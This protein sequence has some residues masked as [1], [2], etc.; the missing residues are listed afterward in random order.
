M[1]YCHRILISWFLYGLTN[2]FVQNMFMLLCFTLPLCS[3]WAGLNMLNKLKKNWAFL[4]PRLYI[5][6]NLDTW[7]YNTSLST[8]VSQLLFNH[9]FYILLYDN[10][11]LLFVLVNLNVWL[12]HPSYCVARGKSTLTDRNKI[13]LKGN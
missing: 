4:A 7:F 6:L 3:C 1:L 13:E 8:D 5:S 2:F 10:S 9:V 11:L 12:T